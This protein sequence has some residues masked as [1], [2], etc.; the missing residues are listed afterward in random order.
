MEAQ[1]VA[2]LQHPNIVQI[3]EIGQYYSLPFISLEFVEGGSLAATLAGNPQ[4]PAQSALMVGELARAV[5]Y[6]HRRGIIHRDLKPS[7]ILLTP[8][9]TPKITDFGLAKELEG[10]VGHTLSGAVMGTP[11]Y[12]APEQALGQGKQV[13]PAADTYALGAILYEMLTGRPPFKGSTV[14]DTLEQVRSEEPV[15]PT[16]LLRNVPRDLETICL[17][18]MAK[19]PA[20]R[21]ASPG[22]FADDLHRFLQREPIQARPVGSI[23]RLWRWCS[24]HRALTSLGLATTVLLVGV[25]AAAIAAAYASREKERER[26]QEVLLQQLQL[27]RL[28]TRTDG[29]SDEAWKLVIEAAAFRKDEM[30]RNKAAASCA[31]LDARSY[32]HVERIGVSSLAFDGDGK[33]LLLGGRNDLAGRPLDGARLWVDGLSSDQVSRRQGA[34]PVAFSPAGEPIHVV[35]APGPSLELWDLRAQKLISKCKFDTLSDC[36]PSPRLT[37][38]DLGFPVAALSRDA[39]VVAGTCRNETGAG[40]VAVWEV[41]SGQILM[42]VDEVADAVALAPGG[43]L[44]AVST[45]D[46][47]I[48]LWSIA[49]RQSIGQ[50]GKL[51]ATVHSLAFS[52]D[53]HRLAAGDSAGT[54]TVWDIAA[55]TPISFCLGSHYEIYAL[56]FSSDGTVLAS[57]GRGPVKLWDSTTG[58][59]ILN[60]RSTGTV[61]ALEF[62]PD[63]QELI[64]GAIAPAR[65]SFWRIERDRGI[66]TFRGLTSQAP[67]LCFSE[68]G[69]YLAAL[70]HKRDLVIWDVASGDLRFKLEAPKGNADEDAALAFNRNASLVA[71][72]ASDQVKL[73]DV[74]TGKELSSWSLPTGVRDALA[75]NNSNQISLFRGEAV[76]GNMAFANSNHSKSASNVC[77]L[78]ELSSP[79]YSRPIIETTKFNRHFLSAASS[80]DGSLFLADGIQEGPNGLNRSV[81]AFDRAS[82]KEIWSV[83]SDRSSLTAS[84]TLDAAGQ[85]LALRPD[86]RD[87]HVV[88]MEAC[89]GRQI[90]S[91]PAFPLC[92]SPQ[93]HFLATAGPKDLTGQERG[94]AVFSANDPNSRIILGLETTPSFHPAFSKDG[95]L[96]AWSNDIG[97]VSVCNLDR[98]RLRLAQVGL[99][100]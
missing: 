72:A 83:S 2:R 10:D 91:L 8:E 11:S 24:R 1:A 67:H 22:E 21:Y 89:S 17:K 64:V 45:V 75:F 49:K 39:R 47:R 74:A 80:C 81:A 12:M 33:R 79:N 73:W 77:R 100:W 32:R 48:S 20:A 51:Q 85:L 58:R 26:R 6:A 15:P 34:G 3:Y 95:Q 98:V 69:N 61:S 14:L 18:A 55:R 37:L 19:A 57:G 63:G 66:Q 23:G 60:L 43:E 29:W 9:G 30:L 16:R 59:L 4:P 88:L 87:N 94:Y 36:S 38:T 40:M 71:C 96:F 28:N 65:L 42:K 99:D 90:G 52:P 93:A 92:L 76:P 41:T 53:G 25:V 56:A 5:D 97:T 70:G 68:E 44:L 62:K 84:L 27:I 13:G 82:G 46:G 50:L 7:N 78:R 54:T 35:A 86:N 31:D